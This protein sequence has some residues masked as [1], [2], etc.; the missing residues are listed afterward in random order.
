MAGGN[1]GDEGRRAAKT[2]HSA[3]AGLWSAGVWPRDPAELPARVRRG[4]AECRDQIGNKARSCPG[5]TRGSE[6]RSEFQEIH[7]LRGMES[8]FWIEVEAEHVGVHHCLSVVQI[9]GPAGHGPVS[10]LQLC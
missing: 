9:A 3:G 7:Q 5:S 1:S 10:E 6:F 8:P 2:H 4:S